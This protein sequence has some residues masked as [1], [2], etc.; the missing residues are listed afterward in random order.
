MGLPTTYKYQCDC[1][2]GSD[3]PDDFAMCTKCYEEQGG[4]A[5]LL[6]HE[7]CLREHGWHLCKRH[8]NKARLAG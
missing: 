2:H 8:Y 4:D 6:C 1:G 5:P 3:N 7:N